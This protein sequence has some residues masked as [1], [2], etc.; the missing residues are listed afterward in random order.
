MTTIQD[1]VA[2]AL[3]QQPGYA[4]R[5]DSITAVAATVL[6]LANLAVLYTGEAPAWLS[7]VLAVVI[8]VAQTAIHAGT[9]GAITPSMAE[10]LEEAAEIVSHENT[11]P[12]YDFKG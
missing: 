2:E 7:L 9:K 4:R 8:G 10:R 11:L 12:V 1:A 3:A 6:Q 5:K